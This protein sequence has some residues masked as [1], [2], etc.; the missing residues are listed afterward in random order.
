MLEKLAADALLFSQEIQS[1]SSYSLTDTSKSS[2]RTLSSCDT[3]PRNE[4]SKLTPNLL[5]PRL[6]LYNSYNSP[7]SNYN[8]PRSNYNASNSQIDKSLDKSINSLTP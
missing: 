5:S 7:R 6:E 1:S 4:N 2:P 8:T 3:T